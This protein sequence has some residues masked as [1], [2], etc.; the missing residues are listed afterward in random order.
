MPSSWANHPPQHPFIAHALCLLMLVLWW[1]NA[2][3]NLSVIWAYIRSAELKKTPVSFAPLPNIMHT[4]PIHFISFELSFLENGLLSSFSPIFWLSIWLFPISVWLPRWVCLRSLTFSLPL[5]GSGAFCSARSMEAL[6]P[7]L[8][9]TQCVA[10]KI[11]IDASVVM[12]NVNVYFS[13]NCVIGDYG[14]HWLRSLQCYSDGSSWK[15]SY[16]SQ[17]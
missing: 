15:A 3:F 6:E 14:G 16:L 4:F 2:I 11:C 8:V 5:I 9:W 10:I 1:F 7:F 17:V 13:R 12:N